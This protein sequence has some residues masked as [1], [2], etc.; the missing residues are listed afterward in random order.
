MELTDDD[1]LVPNMF[2]ADLMDC[3]D[4]SLRYGLHCL[5]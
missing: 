1:T 5:I 4:D 3:L 2:V